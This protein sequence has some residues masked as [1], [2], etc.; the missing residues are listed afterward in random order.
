MEKIIPYT[1]I[2]KSLAYQCS[3][4]ELAELLEWRNTLPENEKLYIELSSEW[5]LINK[6]L[7]QNPV[8]PNK[9]KVW[10]GIQQ[11]IKIPAITYTRAFLIRVAA[12]AAMIALIVGFS[13]SFLLNKTTIEA[14]TLSA[15]FIAPQGQKSQ[16]LLADG[17]KVWLNSGSK[18]TYTNKFGDKDRSVELNGEAFFD[19]IKNPDLKF[20]VKTG[21][22]KVVVHG[23]AFN[24]KSYSKNQDLS[25][26]LVRGSVDVV[27]S[28]DDKSLA[29]LTPGERVIIEKNNLSYKV[30]KCDASLDGIWRLEKLKF[31]GAT[32]AEIAEKLGKW[33]GVNIAIKDT[34]KFQKYWFT[35]KTESLVDILKSMDGLHPIRYSIKDENVVISS[36]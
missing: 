25:V 24:V 26:S 15:V 11:L 14:P 7:N 23:T 27:S 8:Y 21:S 35:V 28:K 32:I 1:L 3:E 33:Y 29:V 20:I 22:V 6:D 30:E 31:E 5:E 36:R 34:N 12:M 17:T 4:I 10:D 13:F 2:A 18:L 16:L 19:V 9:E